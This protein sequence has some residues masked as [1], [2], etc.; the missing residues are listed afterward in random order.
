MIY[1]MRESTNR[2]SRLVDMDYTWT[3]TSSTGAQY[4]T[5]PYTYF[6][7]ILSLIILYT[8]IGWKSQTRIPLSSLTSSIYKPNN[9]KER[10]AP[11]KPFFA[12]G[13]FRLP[14]ACLVKILDVQYLG[15]RNR[16][17]YIPA[18]E[19]SLASTNIG[20]RNMEDVKKRPNSRSQSRAS[21]KY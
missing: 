14:A 17:S 19:Q 3:S 10:L 1:N 21:L 11:D 7:I 20:I 12:I 2:C 5:L 18:S 16:G 6:P 15:R 4:V 13:R 8:I 9:L